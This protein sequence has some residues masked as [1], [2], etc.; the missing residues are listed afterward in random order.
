MF[1]RGTG[2]SWKARRP[3]AVPRMPSFSIRGSIISKP[4][5]SGVTRNAVIS[6]LSVPGTGVRAMTVSTRAMAALVMYRFSPLR[7]KC[8][9]SASGCARV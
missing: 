5:I 9:P 2:M 3:V 4:G 8:E 1:S 7:M 6:V